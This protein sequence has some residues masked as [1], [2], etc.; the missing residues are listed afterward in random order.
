MRNGSQSKTHW[1]LLDPPPPPLGLSI[2]SHGVISSRLNK[3]NSKAAI[4]KMVK[5][6]TLPTDF[7]YMDIFLIAFKSVKLRK[8]CLPVCRG[9]IA[10]TFVR[11][12]VQL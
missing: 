7:Y 3:E 6:N 4:R 5:L 12:F 1:A 8:S 11:E 2:Q 9:D 10:K